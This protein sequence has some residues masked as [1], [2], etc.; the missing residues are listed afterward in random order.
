MSSKSTDKIPS[1]KAR[2]R[3]IN[4]KGKRKRDE[5]DAREEARRRGKKAYR[6]PRCG[7]WHVGGH[8]IVIEYVPG[9]RKR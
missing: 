9:G 5:A 8:R 7:H 4:C 3:W 6:C 1:A 2:R